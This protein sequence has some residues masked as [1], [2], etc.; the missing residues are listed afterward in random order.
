MRRGLWLAWL[1][2]A[3]GCT[4]NPGAAQ[5]ALMQA[6]MRTLQKDYGAAISLYDRALANDSSL[7]EACF[8]R[9]IAYRGTG[10]YDR[11]LAD[12]DKAIALGLDGSRVFSE[13]A[14]TKM[15]KLAA[16]AAGDRATL[17]AAFAPDDPLGISADLDHAADLDPAYTDSVALLLRGAVLLMQGRDAE[18]EQIFERFLRRRPGAQED[19]GAAVAKWKKERPVLDLSPI[20]DLGRMGPKRG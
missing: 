7:I 8:Y 10:N 20:D 9:G 12:M 4:F 17:A 11:A 2:A 1:V 6:N 5:Q 15:E 18:A 14:R 13:R 16:D 3:A 19:L